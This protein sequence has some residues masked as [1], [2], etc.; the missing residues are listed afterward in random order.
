MERD[1]VT[2]FNEVGAV[3]AV[4][5][6]SDEF[7]RKPVHKMGASMIAFGSWDLQIGRIK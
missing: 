7:D 6:D 3:E 2:S 1:L 5:D 4:D